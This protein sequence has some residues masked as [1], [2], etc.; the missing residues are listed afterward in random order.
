MKTRFPEFDFTLDQAKD[1]ADKAPNYLKKFCVENKVMEMIYGG[2]SDQREILRFLRGFCRKNGIQKLVYV[3]ILAE[4]KVKSIAK[5]RASKAGKVHLGDLL[6]PG[7]D[8]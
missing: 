3:D 4:E 5:K 1:W 7:L 2:D 6:G 8:I